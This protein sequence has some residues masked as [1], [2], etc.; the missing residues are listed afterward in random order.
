MHCSEEKD[1]VL[2]R[3]ATTSDVEFLQVHE[4]TY[5]HLEFSSVKKKRNQRKTTDIIIPKKKGGW[6]YQLHFHAKTTLRL[7]TIWEQLH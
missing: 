4:M 3:Q 1:F 2:L 5:S 6:K 7:N